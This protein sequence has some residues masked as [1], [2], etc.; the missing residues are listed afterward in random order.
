VGNSL[1]HYGSAPQPTDHVPFGAYSVEVARF[2]GGWDERLTVNQDFEFDYRLRQAGHELLF[3]PDLLILWR[4][5]QSVTDLFR[6]YHRYGRGKVVVLG[7]HPRALRPRQTLPPL[8][9]AWCALAAGVA[10]RDPRRGAAML[11]P[12][13]LALGAASAS[14]ARRLGPGDRRWVAPA[15]AAMH[16]GWGTGFWRGI[17]SGA[18]AAAATGRGGR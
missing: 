7:K 13:V 14:T 16:V 6:Q 3:D 5:R 18:A 4:S 1:Y 17:L 2:L 9:V 10:L 8:L 12:Y 15:Y 11:A